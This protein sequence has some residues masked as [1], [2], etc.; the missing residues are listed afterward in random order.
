MS[1]CSRTPSHHLK[2]KKKTKTK[3]Q[4]RKVHQIMRSLQ[5]ISGNKTRQHMYIAMLLR[6]LDHW[7]LKSECSNMT[8]KPCTSGT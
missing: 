6:S 4:H 3:Q 1:L 8:E 5:T 2:M 7:M